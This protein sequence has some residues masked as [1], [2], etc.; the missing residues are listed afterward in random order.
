[1]FLGVLS[2]KGIWG[3]IDD[4]APDSPLK[5]GSCF[6]CCP[7]GF[8]P[9]EKLLFVVLTAPLGIGI[10]CC[11]CPW[12][13]VSPRFVLG[14]FPPQGFVFVLCSSGFRPPREAGATLMIPRSPAGVF[15]LKLVAPSFFVFLGVLSPK[16][17]WGGIDDAALASW[18]WTAMKKQHW[19][20]RQPP[21]TIWYDR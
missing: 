12:S 9:Q 11:C 4:A 17:I 7:R 16:G 18:C 20:I 6:C 8:V 19:A 14:D 15:S 3:G 21:P 13:L 2:P 10:C 5:V 1:M